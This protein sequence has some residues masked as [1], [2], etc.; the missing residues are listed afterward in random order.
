MNHDVFISYSSKN[1][2]VADAVVHY[3][4]EN[5]IRCWV[6]PRDIP[7]GSEYGD[8]IIEAIKTTRVFVL[9]YSESSIVS[10]WVKSE[11]NR[12]VA[13]GKVI[14]P[15]KM[16]EAIVAGAMEFYLSD[17]HW[18]DAFPD[19]EKH[20]RKLLRSLQ[21]FLVDETVTEKQRDN[22][23]GGDVS[24]PIMQPEREILRIKCCMV[25][26]GF[27]ALPIGGELVLTNRRMHFVFPDLLWMSFDPDRLD[28][29]SKW[30][31]CLPDVNA[32]SIVHKGWFQIKFCISDSHGEAACFQIA[33]KE[34]AVIDRLRQFVHDHGG[35]VLK[36]NKRR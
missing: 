30:K 35:C 9:L 28:F 11:T 10:P 17:R 36:T 4:E 13:Y 16:D 27:V 2:Q 15:F 19:P 7:P 34:Q 22:I 25:S 20:F 23:G 12:A 8:V 1:K 3:L 31:I 14:I 33:K 18:I 6:A 24:L 32:I 29:A 21:G 5:K 26:E